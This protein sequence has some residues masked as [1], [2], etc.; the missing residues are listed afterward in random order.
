MKGIIKES[1]AFFIGAIFCLIQVAI[2][3]N[4]DKAIMWLIFVF[5]CLVCGLGMKKES[6]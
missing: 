1:T 6:K 3:Y 5:V 4:T 2:N